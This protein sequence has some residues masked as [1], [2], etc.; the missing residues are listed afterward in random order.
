VNRV[1][2]NLIPESGNVGGNTSNDSYITINL[3]GGGGVRIPGSVDLNG[4]IVPN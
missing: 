3:G 4:N 1:I 2:P